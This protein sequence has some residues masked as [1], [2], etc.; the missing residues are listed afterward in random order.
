MEPKV[1]SIGMEEIFPESENI[2]WFEVYAVLD[3]GSIHPDYDEICFDL[4]SAIKTLRGFVYA[5]LR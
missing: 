1:V 5:L 4:D 2:S 3:D